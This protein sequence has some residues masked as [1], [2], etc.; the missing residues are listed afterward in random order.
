MLEIY[1]PSG[2]EDKLVD[3]LEPVMERMGYR[4]KRDSTGNLFGVLGNGKTSVLLLGHLD[5]VEG[6][7]PVR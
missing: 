4:T 2:S 6:E 7:I 1:S 5:T 3:F